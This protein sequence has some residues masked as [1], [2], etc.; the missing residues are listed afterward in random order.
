MNDWRSVDI[1]LHDYSCHFPS[2]CPALQAIWKL[3]WMN[4][5]AQPW[6]ISWEVGLF[7]RRLGPTLFKTLP[8]N[9]D[10]ICQSMI[11][12]ILRLVLNTETVKGEFE[13]QSATMLKRSHGDC[14]LLWRFGLWTWQH[15]IDSVHCKASKPRQTRIKSKSLPNSDEM[16]MASTL[17]PTTILAS[18]HF[19]FDSF[20]TCF[21]R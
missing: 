21:D 12:E 14:Q 15:K 11:K 6:T 19:G 18:S 8:W 1:W 16:L 20:L 13:T 3:I 9:L 5:S 7:L 10:V 4:A 17:S 2:P